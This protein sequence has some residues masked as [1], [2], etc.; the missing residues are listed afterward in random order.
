MKSLDKRKSDLNG[1]FR[2]LKFLGANITRMIL[3]LFAVSIITFILISLSPLD[4]LSSYLGGDT[5]SVS[6]EQV[7]KVADYWG[8]NDSY[9]QRYFH[10]ITGILQGDLGRSVIF[11]LPVSQVIFEKFQ[12]SLL[13]MGIAWVLS[14]LIGFLSGIMAAM[15]HNTWIDKAIKWY[16]LTLASTPTFWI[17]LLLIVIF[18]VGL[19]W[20]PMGLGVPIGVSAD[21]VSVLDRL[22]HLA[23]PAVT[24]SLIGIAN[25]ALHTRSKLLEVLESDYMTFALARGESKWLA[26]KNHGIRNILLPAITLQFAS[27]GELFG[28][29]ALAEQVFSYPG[30]GNTIVQA[31]IKGDIT[32]LVGISLF[33]AL[34]IFTGNF[35]ANVL[36]SV[37]NPKIKEGYE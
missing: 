30:L 15:Y 8:F 10:W 4:P 27:L 31:G 5:V 21:E 13:L 23:L 32:L 36:Y 17:G 11:N 16:C 20:F 18:S 12:A 25:I 7:E 9:V 19:G 22:H 26:V 35:I 29:S 1:V 3:L 28:G 6:E 2:I 33:S 24:L 37:V 34:F 14:G